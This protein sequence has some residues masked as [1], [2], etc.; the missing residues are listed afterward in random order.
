MEAERVTRRPN[1]GLR[2]CDLLT[3]EHDPVIK[4]SLSRVELWSL[5]GVGSWEWLGVGNWEWLGIG[6]WELGIEKRQELLSPWRRM[7]FRRLE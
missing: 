6:S 3:V 1:D 7:I 5:L 2:R 4:E